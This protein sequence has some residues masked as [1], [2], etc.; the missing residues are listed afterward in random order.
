MNNKKKDNINIVILF[1]S[2]L[3]F[4]GMIIVILGLLFMNLVSKKSD[5]KKSTFKYVLSKGKL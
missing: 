4:F 5:N 2:I 3:K 1:L